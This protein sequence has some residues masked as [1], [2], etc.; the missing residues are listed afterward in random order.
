MKKIVALLLFI[1]TKIIISE[2]VYA[3]FP[4]RVEDHFWRKKVLERI[5]L[6]EKL[7]YSLKYKESPLYTK[8]KYGETK[9]IVYALINGYKDGKYIGYQ[10]GALQKPVTYK[11]FERMMYETGSVTPGGGGDTGGDEEEEFEDEGGDEME[12]GQA[13]QT[14]DG[15]TTGDNLQSN[16][17]QGD[18]AIAAYEDYIGIIEDRIFDKNKSDMYYDIQYICL[19]KTDDIKGGYQPQVCFSYKDVMDI[20]DD[21]QYKNPKNDAEYRSI[22]EVIELRMFKSVIEELSGEELDLKMAEK[23]NN[24][25]IEFEHYLWEF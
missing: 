17:T 8:G 20:L 13:E 4:P 19:Y 12:E 24:Q 6:R 21:T 2:Q 11:E 18:P 22:K 14:A 10:F 5:D 1:I 16:N 15:Q 7:N 25:M 3:Q 23:R 9:G